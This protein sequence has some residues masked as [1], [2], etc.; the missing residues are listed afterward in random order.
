MTSFRETMAKGKDG[1]KGSLRSRIN[2]T[3]QPTI[4]GEE[5][6]EILGNRL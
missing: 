6:Q 5:G 3:L 2:K 4:Y 1:V